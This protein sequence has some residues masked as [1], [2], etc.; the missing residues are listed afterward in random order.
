VAGCCSVHHSLSSTAARHV[1]QVL[2]S[3]VLL[4]ALLCPQG[5]FFTLSAT[6]GNRRQH[7]PPACEP[8]SLPSPPIDLLTQSALAP[9][10]TNLCNPSEP[11]SPRLPRTEVSESFGFLRPTLVLTDF[12]L[13]SRLNIISSQWENRLCSTCGWLRAGSLAEAVQVEKEETT[14][15]LGVAQGSAYSLRCPL[16]SSSY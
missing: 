10:P 9:F 12:L 3:Q 5:P 6:G 2:C 15:F 1:L 13:C 8:N 4:L 11:R 14:W 7:A 16:N